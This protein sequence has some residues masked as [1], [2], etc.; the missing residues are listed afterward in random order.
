MGV[1]QFCE[2]SASSVLVLS[3]KDILL[4]NFHDMVAVVVVCGGCG[5]VGGDGVGVG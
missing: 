2:L 5:Q 1:L 4:V 3:V